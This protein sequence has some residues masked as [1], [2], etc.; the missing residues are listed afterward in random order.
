[1]HLIRLYLMCLDIL[2]KEEVCTY[3][4]N[5]RNFLL[6]IRNGAFQNEDGTYRPEF[7]ELVTDYE[8][9]LNYAKQNTSLPKSPDM[10]QIEEF[11]IAV[12]RRSLDD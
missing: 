1:M 7:F 4:E 11:V 2:E 6:S 3:R 9:R 5:D 10:K 8:K 12:N